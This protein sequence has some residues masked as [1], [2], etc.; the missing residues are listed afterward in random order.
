MM[1]V[2]RLALVVLLLA[3]CAAR[4]SAQQ[5]GER[6]PEPRHLGVQLR[7]LLGVAVLHAQQEVGSEQT[8][9]DGIGPAFEF[10]LGAMVGEQLALNMDIVLAHSPAAEHGVLEETVF[11]ALHA[12]AGITYWFMPANF[13]LGASIGA[14]RSSVEGKP[15]RVGIEVPA[16]D[17]SEVGIGAHVAFGKQFWLTRRI[18]LGAAL[19]LLSSIA[20]N[21]IGGEDS[22]RLV[23][24]AA[25][26]L[27]ATLH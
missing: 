17:P 11:T 18:G 10:A 3:A 21:P 20:P 14:A 2:R 12:G 7:T 5:A 16:S 23:F 25:F 27:S 19:S 4:G 15:V 6:Q 1:T 22:A 24:G 13:Y 9:I 26:A 8:E